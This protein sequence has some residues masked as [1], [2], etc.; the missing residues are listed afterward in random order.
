M[1]RRALHDEGSRA[2]DGAA[3]GQGDG[4]FRHRAPAVHADL[5]AALEGLSGMAA[6]APPSRPQA[7]LFACGSI[8][9]ARRWRRRCCGS[10]SAHRS[11]S[12][13]PACARASST[14]SRSPPWRRSASISPRHRPITFEEL[15]DL[16]G[17]QLR[18]DR[19]AVAGS[20]PQGAGAH[21]RL[22]AEVEYW[23][24]ADPSAVE[25]NREQRLDA[26]RD[27]R[28]QLIE[29]IRSRFR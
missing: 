16:G 6:A 23:P 26:Y 24:T 9:C 7:V 28:D 1:G 21:P 18:P 2:P 27:V 5:R 11:M 10:C 25:G 3:Q 14:R 17:P 8:R 15:E 22:A 20:P 13:R 12:A 29:R 19:H 4:R